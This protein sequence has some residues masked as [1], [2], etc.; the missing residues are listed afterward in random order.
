MRY[1]IRVNGT[2]VITVLS[3]EDLMYYIIDNDLSIVDEVED[4]ERN[5]VTINCV[6]A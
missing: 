1:E 3:I 4:C 5:F 6:E 2:L